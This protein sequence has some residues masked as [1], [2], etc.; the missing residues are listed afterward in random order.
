MPPSPEETTPCNAPWQHRRK[1]LATHSKHST[2]LRHQGSCIVAR[3]DNSMHSLEEFDEGFGCVLEQRSAGYNGAT[4]P[5]SNTDVAAA[6]GNMHVDCAPPEHGMAHG[7]S[8]HVQVQVLDSSV[9]CGHDRDRAGQ[10]MCHAHGGAQKTVTRLMVT[11]KQSFSSVVIASHEEASVPTHQGSARYSRADSI[12][13]GVHVVVI[14]DPASYMQ[15][16]HCAAAE[17]QHGAYGSEES[18]EVSAAW[19][20]SVLTICVYICV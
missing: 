9:T 11:Q 19:A 3:K 5:P 13:R 2:G 20:S 16:A 7:V 12:Q 18:R 1:S 17:Q 4:V 15:Q 14:K 8:S 6:I 10:D